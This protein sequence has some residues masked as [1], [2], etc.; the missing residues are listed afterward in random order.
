MGYGNYPSS[1]SILPAFW[2]ELVGVRSSQL[3]TDMVKAREL[4]SKV[5]ATS[6]TTSN[7]CER[8]HVMVPTHHLISWFHMVPTIEPHRTGP[9]RCTSPIAWRPGL[10]FGRIDL[11]LAS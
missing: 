9:K 3:R 11:K 8:L 4:P 10:R 1:K 6:S 7:T 2:P 5:G